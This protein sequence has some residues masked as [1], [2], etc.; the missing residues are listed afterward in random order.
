MWALT[1]GL[2]TALSTIFSLSIKV[3][4]QRIKT[5]TLKSNETT[6]TLTIKLNL[7][8][9]IDIYFTHYVA[10]FSNV[11]NNNN[12]KK[13][14]ERNLKRKGSVKN[15]DLHVLLYIG[16]REDRPVHY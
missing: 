15:T 10:V 7:A 4:Y 1:L 14:M 16:L 8:F 3:V 9:L 6:S 11:S 12:E 5:T 2:E 13:E